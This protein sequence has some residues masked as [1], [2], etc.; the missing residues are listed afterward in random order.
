MSSEF[1]HMVLLYKNSDTLIRKITEF[2]TNGFAKGE[3]ATL[4]LRSAHEQ[5]LEQELHL[6]GYDLNVLQATKRLTLHDADDTLKKLMVNGMP[7]PRV[8]AGILQPIFEQTGPQA[9][10]IRIYGEMVAVLW[11]EGNK[12]AALALEQ[13]WNDSAATQQYDLFCAYSH[14]DLSDTDFATVLSDIDR[15]H[16]RVITPQTPLG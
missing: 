13:M 12:R 6:L 10:N 14:A 1:D 3:P 15:C 16:S 5:L 7:D 8:F 9:G 2:V 11:A 4:V